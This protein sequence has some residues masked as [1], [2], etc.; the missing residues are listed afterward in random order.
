MSSRDYWEKRALE[1]RL[2]AEQQTLR[3][4]RQIEQ[5]YDRATA[6]IQKDIAYWLSK[7]A[8]NNQ[9]SMTEAKKLLKADELEEFRWTVEE[10]IRHGENNLDGRWERQLVNASSRVHISRLESLQTQIRQQVE[11]LSGTSLAEIES[12]LGN[13]YQNQYYH[14]AFDIQKGLGIGWDLQ[15]LDDRKVKAV[16]SRPW[17]ADGKV[18]SDRI[19]ENKTQLLSELDTEITRTILTGKK[20][21]DAI[22]N[23]ALRCQV[24]KNQAARLVMTEAAAIDSVAQ[25]QCYQDLDVEEFENVATLDFKASEICREMDGKHFPMSEYKIGVTAPPFHPWCRTCTAPYFDDWE[26]LGGQPMRAARDENGQGYELVPA[27]LTYK[28][29]EKRFVKEK[30]EPAPSSGLQTQ[31]GSAI[32][33]IAEPSNQQ[34]FS[35]IAQALPNA[36]DEYRTEIEKHF[37]EGTTDAQDVFVKYVASGSVADGNYAGTP[38]F[39]SRTQKVKMNFASDLADPRGPATTFFHEHGHYIDFMSCSGS[40]YTSLQTSDFGDALRADFDAYIKA[41]MKTHSTRKK[42]DAYAII[43]QELQG[44][45]HNAISDLFGGMSRNKCAGTY[46]HWNTRYWTYSGMLEK[47]AFAHMFAAQFDAERYALMQKYFPTALAEFEKLLK[48]VIPL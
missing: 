18:F 7:F 38:H 48:G 29:W 12:L 33:N 27:D 16:L 20:W 43:S 37:S 46:G 41:T 30:P 26:E 15:K 17:A 47:E 32:I 8:D 24:S 14:T 45:L 6:E 28:E 3:S 21:D 23:I 1:S 2:R 10:Y 9:I 11:A 25:G 31:Q 22:R 39:D 44:A 13:L 42:T 5:A 36:P 35:Q 34:Y 19:W 40:D 4:V